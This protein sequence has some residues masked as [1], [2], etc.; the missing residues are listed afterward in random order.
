MS[1]I[2]GANQS[3][4][5]FFLNKFDYPCNFFNL[6]FIKDENGKTFVKLKQF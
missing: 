2:I 4:L 6:S 5:K 1:N 3:G